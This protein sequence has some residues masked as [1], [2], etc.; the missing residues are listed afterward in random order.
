MN[1]DA[2]HFFS[3]AAF[4]GREHL[5]RFW[6]RDFGDTRGAEARIFALTFGAERGEDFFG[7]D[8]DFVYATAYGVVDGVGDCGHDGEERALADLL[9]AE[10]AVGVCVLD[11]ISDHVAHLKSRRTLVFEERG[12]LVYDVSV[13]A[14]DHLLH[15]RF[16]QA[17]VD[18]AFDL[19][20]DEKRVD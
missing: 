11:E 12:E 16:A 7:R 2:R 19:S 6:P 4:G 20:H 5:E 17:H 15:E 18:R 8:G 13:L 1:S 3:V 14:I 10:G 9:R